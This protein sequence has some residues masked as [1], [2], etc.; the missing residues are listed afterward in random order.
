[1]LADGGSI[2]FEADKL[3]DPLDPPI[4]S[5]FKFVEDPNLRRGIR[6]TF[7]EDDAI[8]VRLS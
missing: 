7:E 2:A 6:V 4:G 3:Y 1:M 8:L 5:C